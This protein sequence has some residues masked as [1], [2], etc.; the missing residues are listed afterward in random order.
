MLLTLSRP[1]YWLAL[2]AI[3]AVLTWMAWRLRL[4]WRPA[5]A[6]RLLLLAAALGGIILPRTPQD[7]QPVPPPEVLVLDVSDSIPPEAQADARLRAERWQSQQAN[8]MLVVVG[9]GP[10]AVTATAWPDPDGRS[11]NLAAGLELAA[12]LL[13]ERS[14][15]VIVFTDGL[16]D[17]PLAVQNRISEFLPRNQRVDL[18]PVDAQTDENDLFVGSLILPTA[19]WENTA[20]LA[21][22]PVYS[23]RALEAPVEVRVN[24]DLVVDDAYPLQAGQNYLSFNLQTFSEEIMAI[25]AEVASGADPNPSNNQAHAALRVFPA[26]N[27]LIVS[28]D[29]ASAGPLGDALESEGLQTDIFAPGIIPASVADLERYQVIVLH[30]FLANRLTEAQ[31]RTL[32][33]YVSELG[34]GLLFLGGRNAYTLGGY[35]NTILEPMLPVQLQPPPRA[36]H[37]PVT[38]VLAFDRSAS[39]A[40]RRAAVRPIDLAREAAMRAIETLSR[41]DYLGVLTYNTFATWT[42]SLSLVSDGLQLREAQDAISQVQASGGTSIFLALETA[43]NRLIETPTSQARHILLLSDGRSSDGTLETFQGLARFAQE[44]GITLSTIALGADADLELME[45]L[46]TAGNGRYYPV[47]SAADLPRI[48]IAESQ[49]ARSENVFQGE[50][51]LL[52]GEEAHPVLSGLSPA[53]LPVLQGYNALE[54]K[55]EQGAEDVLLSAAFQDPVLSVWQYGLGRVAA[56]TSDLGEEWAGDW[57]SWQKNGQFW[58]QVVRYALPDPAAGPGRALFEVGPTEMRASAQLQSAAGIPLN[59]LEVIFSFVD[60]EGQVQS[61][62]LSQTAPGVYEQ[63]FARPQ[64]GVYRAI[65]LYRPPGEDA[66]ELAAPIV[67][68]FPPEWVPDSARTGQQNLADWAAD[69]GGQMITWEDLVPAETPG[70][71]PS[72]KP[73]NFSWLILALLILWPLEIAIR[74]RWL[75]WRQ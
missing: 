42:V 13:D 9:A 52:P 51:G 57:I 11:S 15:R 31:M 72:R 64:Q 60:A 67:V 6:L 5:W 18:L 28:D 30:N 24:G 4:R 44:Q 49:A 16:A 32:E 63:T 34:R 73:A 35:R 19:L 36:Q 75:P 62:R 70:D 39:M 61:F 20:F 65:V 41:E 27:V 17:D 37:T 23:S 25:S 38:I 58:A 54:S 26:P 74:R 47:L 46:A 33:R 59:G 43:I 3:A 68:N 14:G 71:I 55:A 48:V 21:V 56:W 7:S 50:T 2:L 69:S 45:A 22:L 29:L 66:I 1:A 12:A 53:E 40:Q 8:R 10:A